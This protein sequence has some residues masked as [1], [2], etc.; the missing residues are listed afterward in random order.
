MSGQT[1]T[2]E[3]L[4]AE[5][6][7]LMVG[8]RQVTLSVKRQLDWVPAEECEPFGRISDPQDSDDKD[9]VRVIGKRIQGGDLVCAYTAFPHNW[10]A[11][12]EERW[13]DGF[14]PEQDYLRFLRAD[15]PTIDAAATR[16]NAWKALPLI[17]LAGLR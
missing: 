13:P 11:P 2:V 15:L 12:H 16:F 14:N 5:V 6:R 17:V 10:H 7:V 8:N 3:T 1:A 4:T 9:V